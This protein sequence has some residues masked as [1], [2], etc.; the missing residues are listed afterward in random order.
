MNA[1]PGLKASLFYFCFGLSVL[2]FLVVL[3]RPEWFSERPATVIAATAAKA[4]AK[5]VSS[6]AQPVSDRRQRLT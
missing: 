1:M 6:E 4:K 5:A 3:E 2:A